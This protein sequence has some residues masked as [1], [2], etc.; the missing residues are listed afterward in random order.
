MRSDILAEAS[1][2][3][4]VLRTSIL[5]GVFSFVWL[6]VQP[7]RFRRTYESLVVVLIGLP[8][9]SCAQGPTMGGATSGIVGE[10]RSANLYLRI[11]SC[12]PVGIGT[13][14]TDSFEYDV[15]CLTTAPAICTVISPVKLIGKI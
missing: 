10:S 8:T 6:K 14:M 4:D 5:V 7:L 3:P 12:V 9:N 13:N 2:T 15:A 1:S 11:N